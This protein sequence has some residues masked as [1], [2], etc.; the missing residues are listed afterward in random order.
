MTV[1]ELLKQ[2]AALALPRL[3]S[4]PEPVALL[5]ALAAG[6]IHVVEFAFTT[7]GVAD[8]IAASVDVDGVRVGAGTVVTAAQ[9]REA[10]A[11]GAS[12]LVTPGVVTEVAEAATVPVIMGAFTP[13]E[14][15]T[16]VS[17]GAAAVKIFPA[18]TVGPA[19]FTHL[20]GPFPDMPLVASGGL[21]E[22]NAGEYIRAG[23]LA[24]T[25]G[26]SVVSAADVASGN[27][28]AVTARASAFIVAAR[29]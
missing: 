19:Y 11:A 16:A 9:A 24:V 18:S 22:G 28:D 4:I 3:S 26:S 12:F 27:W 5:R 17:L 2:D 23:A 7:P 13:T 6:G 10:I 8:V 20:H 29:S 1:L 21:H 14:A 15:L 25:A